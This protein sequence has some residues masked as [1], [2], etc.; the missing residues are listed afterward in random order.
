MKVLITGGSGLLGSKLAEVLIRSNYHVYTGFL[1]HIPTLGEK[2]RVDITDNDSVDQVFDKIRPDVVV[3]AAAL[4]NVDK[5][6]LDQELAY[7]TNVLGT[8]NI[9]RNSKKYSAFLVYVSTDYVFDGKKGLYSEGDEPNPINYYGYTKL[10]G[11]QEVKENLDE[12]CIVRPS[13]IF[14]AI[15][16]TGKTNFV[17]WVIDRL[18]KHEKIKI[19]TDQWVSPTLNT[20]L[21]YMINEIIERKLSG[22]LH[23]S[24]ATRINRFDFVKLIAKIFDLNDTLIY[25]VNMDD[26]RWVARRPRDSSLNV[27]KAMRLLRNKPWK[28]DIALEFLKRELS[29]I[30]MG[31]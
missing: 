4:T 14:G 27:N 24:G 18:S 7:R 1:K 26:I 22:L 16:A 6:E 29:N 25:P 15:T 10:L 2:V 3:H 5:C 30:K 13:V 9:V 19:V 31:S 23:L 8:R 28:V 11:E 20:N 17:L 12:F 21:A